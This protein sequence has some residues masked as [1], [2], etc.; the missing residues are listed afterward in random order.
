[1]TVTMLTD[2]SPVP[3][4]QDLSLLSKRELQVAELVSRGHTNREIARL[5]VVSPK[6]VETHL[7]RI[8]SKLDVPSRAA[9]A[10]TV[11]RAEPLTPA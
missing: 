7:S 6:T 11:A 4:K 1:M 10:S 5:L 2:A 9:V 8:F 3:I